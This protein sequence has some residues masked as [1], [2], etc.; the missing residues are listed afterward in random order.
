MFWT[1][2]KFSNSQNLF[3]LLYDKKYLKTEKFWVWT[4][5]KILIIDNGYFYIYPYFFYSLNIVIH[6][7]TYIYYS[8]YT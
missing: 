5:P 7:F 6:K 4:I 2:Q 8:I 3:H 1:G